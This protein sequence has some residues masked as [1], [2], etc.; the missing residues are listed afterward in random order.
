MQRTTKRSTS[1][2][3]TR[4]L[5]SP[6]CKLPGCIS[7]GSDV[8]ASGSYIG[9]PLYIRNAFNV[10]EVS[11]ATINRPD[12]AKSTKH[13][14]YYT[15]VSRPLTRRSAPSPSSTMTCWYRLLRIKAA[16]P[17][18]N[19]PESAITRLTGGGTCIPHVTL[20]VPMSPECCGGLSTA[21]SAWKRRPEALP[22]QIYNFPS[23]LTSNIEAVVSCS[24][25]VVAF[26]F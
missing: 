24:P 9:I 6:L 5:A 22:H 15:T 14:E 20:D 13:P 1:V 18:S 25:T 26:A 12:N 21:N 2:P 10:H 23:P 8:V 19:S 3:T 16:C 17:V 7:D 4:I 11:K